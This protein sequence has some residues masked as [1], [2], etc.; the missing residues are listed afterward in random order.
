MK[1]RV[2]VEALNPKNGVVSYLPELKELSRQNRNNPTRAEQKLWIEIL[3]NK[4]TG[5]IFLRQ[6]PIDRFIVDYYCSQLSL[7]IEVD[8]DYHMNQ[9]SYDLQRDLFLKQIGIN[10]IRF[11]NDEVLNDIGKVRSEILSLVKGRN[12]TIGGERD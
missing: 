3:S 1:R 2:V 11:S 6:K 5:F 7:V 9:K 4:K 12:P 8:G 10:T